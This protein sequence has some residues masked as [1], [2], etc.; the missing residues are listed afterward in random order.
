LVLLV[1]ENLHPRKET[2]GVSGISFNL[3]GLEA[4]TDSES[5]SKSSVDRYRGGGRLIL[6]LS[7]GNFSISECCSAAFAA[8]DA[9]SYVPRAHKKSNYYDVDLY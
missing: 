5:E 4:R 1:F 9:T 7:V 8:A 6:H 2:G 3:F